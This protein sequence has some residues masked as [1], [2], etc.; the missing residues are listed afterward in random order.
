MFT[1]IALFISSSFAAININTATAS[2][3][4]AFSGVGAA[5]AA[6]I[7]DF[8]ESTARFSLVMIS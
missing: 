8:R 7:I 1:L 6:K 3:L 2:E 5:T 4:E